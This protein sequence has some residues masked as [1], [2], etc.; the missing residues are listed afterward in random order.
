MLLNRADRLGGRIKTAG[1][2]KLMI[3]ND[4]RISA[5]CGGRI[6]I[7]HYCSIV[8]YKSRI[9]YV[10]HD[11]LRPGLPQWYQTH[12]PYQSVLF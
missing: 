11:F 5:R 7:A 10:T 12:D 1:A 8:R 4:K 6:N 9:Q 3:D 2:A